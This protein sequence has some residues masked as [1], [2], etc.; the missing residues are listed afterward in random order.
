MATSLRINGRWAAEIAG[1]GG[2]AWKTK[3]PGGVDEITWSMDTD[4]SY[5]HPALRSGVLVELF[6]GPERI[7]AG[8]LTEPDIAAG[9]FTATGLYRA[10]YGHALALDS[11][12]APT[13]TPNTAIDEALARGA[14]TIKRAANFSSF[15]F[16]A[17]A[18]NSNKILDLLNAFSDSTGSWPVVDGWGY[19]TNFV[20]PTT[21]DLVLAPG[22]V[23]LGVA[24]DD[25]ASD[26]YGTRLTS[27][28]TFVVEHRGDA[29]ARAA[30]GRREEAVDLTS[31]GVITE[32]KAEAILDGLL[33][34]GAARPAFT[35]AITV[36]DGMLLNVNGAP[37]DLSTV[38]AGQVVRSSGL[39]DD[40]ADLGQS[41]LDWV[42]GE[43]AYEAGS[44][45]ISLSPLGLSPRDLATVLATLPTPS[46]MRA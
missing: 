31:L 43:T 39:Y 20:P 10:E 22:S 3:L 15:A 37:V 45:V 26:L 28:G 4:V 21:P 38:T 16:T 17:E 13:T 42:I 25:Y 24:E 36:A 9:T 33:A 8:R 12:G 35:K 34:K 44:G 41:H 6:D 18:N 32:A 5:R 19:I 30:Y 14:S 27:G 23:D 2:L 40:V 29:D 1:W 7:G 46:Y 11:S